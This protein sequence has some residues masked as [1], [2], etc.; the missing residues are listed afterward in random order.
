MTNK[1]GYQLFEDVYRFNA[2]NIFDGI[3]FAIKVIERL[4]SYDK[5]VVRFSKFD[6]KNQTIVRES[7]L[8]FD[9][10]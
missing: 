10:K 3:N 1:K 6:A 8:L 9:V 7:R 4:R 2:E 5:S